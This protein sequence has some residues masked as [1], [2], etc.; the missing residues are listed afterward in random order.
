M[1][2]S[3]RFWMRFLFA[4]LIGAVATADAFGAPDAQLAGR[5]GNLGEATRT[6]VSSHRSSKAFLTL[7]WIFHSTDFNTEGPKFGAWSKKGDYY[8][9][10]ERAV[11]GGKGKDLVRVEAESG[12][13]TRVAE[14]AW[15]TPVEAAA[16]LEP[17]GFEFSED[18]S[19]LLLFANTQRVWRRNTR[20][21]YWLL[22]LESRKLQK[23]GGDAPAASLMFAKFSP[24][25]TKVGFVREGNL[26]VQD[27]KNFSITALTSGSGHLIHGTSDWVYEE[28]LDLRDAYRWSPDGRHIAFWQFDVSEVPVFQLINFTDTDYPKLTPIVYPKAGE[29][30]SSVRLGVVSVE[31][32]PIRWLDVPGDPRNHYPAHMEWVPGTSQLLIQQFNRAQNTNRVFLA[33]SSTGVAR[34]IHQEHDSA[35]LENEN[36]VRWLDGGKSF[37]WLSERRGWRHALKVPTQGGGQHN[38]T[39]G[40]FDVIQVEAVDESRGWLYFAASPS[41]PVRRYLYRAPLQGGPM[42]R[43]TPMDQSGWHA[44]SVSPNGRWAIHT[45]SAFLTPP[46]V[47]LVRLPSH[48][49]VRT[50]VTNEKVRKQLAALRRLPEVQFHRIPIESGDSLD[51]WSIRP[52]GRLGSGRHPLLFYVYGEPH[53]QTVRDVWQGSRG[54]WHFMLAQQGCIVA[55][56]DNRGT[57]SPRGRAWRRAPHLK[58]GILPPSDQAEAARYMLKHWRFVDRNRVGIWGWSGGGSMSLNAIFKYPELYHTA[59]AIAPVP[60]MKLY[61]TIYQERYMG[62]PSENPEGY[63]VGSPLHFA[64]NLRGNLFVAHGTGDDNCHYQGVERLVNE[65]VA[66]NKHFEFLPYPNRSHSISEGTNTT[67]HLYGSMTRFIEENLIDRESGVRRAR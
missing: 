56:V 52:S 34:Q 48:E 29:R 44:Y 7:D 26:Y 31:G 64:H 2:A 32:G 63:R 28:E 59:L 14:A 23:L 13:V 42:E 21:D 36:A 58:L 4:A 30:N 57:M 65:L 45:F 50:L 20:G 11:N 40:N 54:L 27:L 19:K 49:V 8:F 41:D 3:H 22:D 5:G 62:L 12:S 15:M 47:E 17:T 38:L 43:L 6:N 25:A 16:P 60:D 24:D 46:V 39:T 61:D 1:K 18:E 33:E 53:G 66:H 55:S 9:Y 35:W 51:A 37:L 10:F 67:R